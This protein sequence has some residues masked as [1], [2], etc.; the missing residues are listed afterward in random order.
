MHTTIH[1][2]QGSVANLDSGT[3]SFAQLDAAQAR[4]ALLV[5]KTTME[6]DGKKKLTPDAQEQLHTSI[7]NWLESIRLTGKF[8]TELASPIVRARSV[9]EI[10][11]NFIEAASVQSMDGWM[12]T[13]PT[14][15]Q[16]FVVPQA[17]AETRSI[18][19]M[20][21]IAHMAAIAKAKALGAPYNMDADLAY[22]LSQRNQAIPA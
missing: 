1:N 17:F 6:Q 8:L 3:P 18:E 12:G 21:R 5:V 22:Q 4:R 14:G 15:Q 13:L 9:Q 10:S 2:H 11:N 7:S 20:G 19:E 16:V